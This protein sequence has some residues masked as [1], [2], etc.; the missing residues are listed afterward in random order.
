[1]VVSL[2]LQRDDPWIPRFNKPAQAKFFSAYRTQKGDRAVIGAR[3]RERGADK[4][5]TPAA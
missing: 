2:D 1:M 4:F 5:A 3:L